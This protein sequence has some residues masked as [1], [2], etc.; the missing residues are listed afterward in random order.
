MHQIQSN[1]DILKQLGYIDDATQ[2]GIDKMHA[3]MHAAPYVAGGILLIVLAIVL[4]RAIVYEIMR[5]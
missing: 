2:H 4:Y 5:R 3:I 1:M